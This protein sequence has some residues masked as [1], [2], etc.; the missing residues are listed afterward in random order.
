MPLIQV[1]TYS[2]IIKKIRA[3]IRAQNKNISTLPGSVAGDLFVV[4]QA[5]SD[6]QQYAVIYYDSIQSS[7]LELLALKQDP[8]TR[9]LIAQA[10]S[11]TDDDL[12]ADIS[13]QFDRIGK[14]LGVLRTQ[15]TPATGDALF[16]RVDPPTSDLTVKVGTVV[17]SSAGVQYQTMAPAVMYAAQAGSYYNP[18]LELFAISVPVQAVVAGSNGNSPAGTLVAIVTPVTGL[19]QVTNITDMDDGRDLE[20]DESY[21]ADILAK[22]QAT[23]A[24]T[25]AGIVASAKNNAQVTGTYLAPPGDPLSVRGVGKTDLYI[26]NVVETQFTE[27]FSAF[28]SPLF[29]DGIRPTNLP[30]VNL[31]SV[32]SGTAFPQKDTTTALAASVRSQ[33]AIRFSVPP[34]F[35]VTITYTA[36][37]RVAQTQNVY[38]TDS[39]TPINYQAPT[40]DAAAVA[41]P[42]LVK[43]APQLSVDYI[44]TITVLPGFIKSQVI[45]QVQNA[46]ATY[47]SGLTLGQTVYLADLNQIVEQV[48]GVLRVA[49]I[50]SKFAPTTGSGV[51][52]SITPKAN[53]YIVLVNIGIF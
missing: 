14:P 15:P 48:P 22:W 12:L 20:S 28:N 42:L 3:R 9:A 49:G 21:A 8:Q 53:A 50:P 44:T 41:T 33:D 10:L 29:S 27:T 18:D 43:A 23:G 19:P 39:L 24:V 6:V 30:L 11:I 32:S 25:K 47:S 45:P 17:R 5:L 38:D 31:I 13:S 52:Q 35:P 46:L 40:T 37:N 7:V 2:D 34:T 4:P 26:Q 36:N 51:S 16:C 1:P